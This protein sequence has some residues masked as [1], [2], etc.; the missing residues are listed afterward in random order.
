M[1]SKDL[2]K[3]P[4]V[5]R[6]IIPTSIWSTLEAIAET[7]S[8]FTSEQ[9]SVS[10][11]VPTKSADTLSR[12]LSYLKYLGIVNETRKDKEQKFSLVKDKEVNDLIYEIKANRTNEAK[13]KWHSILGN[14]PMIKF[15]NDKFFHDNSDKTFIDLEHFLKEQQ[16]GE[17][18]SYYQQGGIA[19][20]ML[21][22]EAGFVSINGN[23]IIPANKEEPLNEEVEEDSV[24]E[25]TTQVE[26]YASKEPNIMPSTAVTLKDEYRII[27]TSPNFRFD[28]KI[29]TPSQLAL[30]EN[31]LQT[32]RAELN[33]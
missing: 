31:A 24:S 16:P 4:N 29:E 22:E 11:K 10:K 20:M 6:G 13:A 2:I 18:P 32:I 3:L 15:I 12:I 8:I 14:H 21:F 17:A 19:L 1:A 25:D 7:G 28:V 30:A 27:I 9:L 23:R 5:K 26:V 33:F